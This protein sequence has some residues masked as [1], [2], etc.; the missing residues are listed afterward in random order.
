LVRVGSAEQDITKVEILSA[1]LS[2]G[3]GNF[4]HERNLPYSGVQFSFGSVGLIL[5]RIMSD[6]LMLCLSFFAAF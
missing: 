3:V 4:D 1:F 6:M 2:R 5:T